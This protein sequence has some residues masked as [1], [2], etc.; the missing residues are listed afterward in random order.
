MSELQYQP[1]RLSDMKQLTNH[2]PGNCLNIPIPGVEHQKVLAPVGYKDAVY[3]RGGDSR[4]HITASVIVSA[5]GKYVSVRLVY[6][7]VRPRTSKLRDLPQAEF[8][9]GIFG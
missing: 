6:P 9:Q 1:I 3:V 7:G 4:L 5:N 2:R 8:I